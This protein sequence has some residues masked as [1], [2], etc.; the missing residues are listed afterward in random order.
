MKAV[1]AVPLAAQARAIHQLLYGHAVSLRLGRPVIPSSCQ[2]VLTRHPKTT[3]CQHKLAT[4]HQLSV[5]CPC[6]HP[7]LIPAPKSLTSAHGVMH[8]LYT[9]N[10]HSVIASDVDPKGTMHA[11]THHSPQLAA[12]TSPAFA[13]QI[14]AAP[15]LLTRKDYRG[16]SLGMHE[17]AQAE[18]ELLLDIQLGRA[19]V[20]HRYMLELPAGH[21]Q[22]PDTDDA[23]QAVTVVAKATL[24]IKGFVYLLADI[25]GPA[26]LLQV[27][28]AEFHVPIRSGNTPRTK[29]THA[30]RNHLNAVFA[31]P[32]TLA[33][34]RG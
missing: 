31:H 29:H 14:Y 21:F 22:H 12:A 11:R 32:Q 16:L 18:L 15:S 1:S 25:I 17:P 8:Q 27:N 24:K 2:I 30:I 7:K 33:R 13:T 4:T 34:Y 26:T 19:L 28:L 10:P 23:S 5:E 9:P 3:S 20:H 6:T